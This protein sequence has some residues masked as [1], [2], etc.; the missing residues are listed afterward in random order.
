LTR[1]YN[2]RAPAAWDYAGLALS[3]IAGLCCLWQLPISE[4]KRV[5]LTVVFVPVGIFVLVF[6]ALFFECVVFG[7]CM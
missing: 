3:M 4:Q 2:F 6:Y 7:D 5:L 1:H